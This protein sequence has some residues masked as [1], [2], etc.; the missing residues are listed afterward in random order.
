MVNRA[1]AFIFEQPAQA[2]PAFPR[3]TTSM[4]L[5]SAVVRH[6]LR[7]CL[8]ATGLRLVNLPEVIDARDYVEPTTPIDAVHIVVDRLSIFVITYSADAAPHRPSGRGTSFDSLAAAL[9]AVATERIGLA[10]RAAIPSP[11][12]AVELRKAGRWQEVLTASERVEA[13]M[14]ARLGAWL[15]SWRF[16]LFKAG[17]RLL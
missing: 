3:S 12:R 8:K 7:A 16:A 10:G 9:R 2:R 6:A 5:R 13:P 11:K 17:L 1:S 15:R 4:S 14:Q